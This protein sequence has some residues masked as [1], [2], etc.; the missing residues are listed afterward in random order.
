MALLGRSSR[1]PRPPPVPLPAFSQ[2]ISPEKTE[3]AAGPEGVQTEL[4]EE[5]E[6]DICKVWDMS[7]DEVGA[8]PRGRVTA[9]GSS[10]S[11]SVPEPVGSGSCWQRVTRGHT[12]LGG[13]TRETHGVGHLAVFGALLLP[14]CG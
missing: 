1:S 14:W 11:A 12:E 7:M 3:P 10:C 2:V 6:N 13:D 5:M 8:R 4:D 9:P